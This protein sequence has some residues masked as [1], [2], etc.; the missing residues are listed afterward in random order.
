MLAAIAVIGVCMAAALA[1][2]RASQG[3]NCGGNSAALH[4]VR[5]YLILVQA[6][7][8]QNPD[9]QFVIA[10][11]TP[12]ERAELTGIVN[13]FWV[14]SVPFLVSRLPCG[15]PTSERRRIII[16]CSRP[17]TNVPS[18]LLGFAPPAHAAAFSDG[19]VEL[20]SVQEFESLD[21]SRFAPLDE[22]LAEPNP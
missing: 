16:V 11:A 14:R 8:A 7:V 21:R 2:A 10:R 19:S 22:L 6:A 1:F 9:H 20:I 4:C 13:D 17:F 5:L 3:S 18:R 12:E 15:M